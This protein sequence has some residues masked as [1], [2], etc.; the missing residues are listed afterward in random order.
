[1]PGRSAGGAG[2]RRPGHPPPT[3]ARG[4]TLAIGLLVLLIVACAAP[5]DPGDAT[6]A[7][8]PAPP[9]PPTTLATTAP[10]SATEPGP[11]ASPDPPVAV[12]AVAATPTSTVALAAGSPIG[13]ATATHSPSPT[14]AEVPTP[15]PERVRVVGGSQGVNMRR[16]PGTASAV[17]KAVRDGTDVTIVGPD[18]E[19]EGRIWRNVRDGDAVGWIVATALR[20]APTPTATPAPTPT[21]PAT[22]TPTSTATPSPAPTVSSPPAV[23]PTGA[24]TPP[25]ATPR[26]ERVEVVGTGGQGANLRAE[27]GTAGRLL[28]TV[29]DG[30]RLA[31]VG[32]DRE[33]DGRTWRNVRGDGGT[34]GWLIDEAVRPVDA[35]EPSA[36]GTPPAPGTTPPAAT[37]TPTAGSTPGPAAGLTA[38]PALPAPT[39]DAD[40]GDNGGDNEEPATP[41][42][43]PTPTPEPER[44]EVYGSDPQGANLRARPGRGGAVRRSLPDG[45]RLTIVGEDQVVDGV[46][47]RNVQTEDG[48]IGWLALE[49]VRTVVTPTPTPR[50]GSAGI[51]APIPALEQPP[52]EFSEAERAATP[53]RPGQLKGDAASGRYYRPDHPDYAGLRL[54]VRCFDE[55]SR[56][57]ASGFLPAPPPGQGDDE[58]APDAPAP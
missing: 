37:R 25:P 54:R 52:E 12:V 1:M 38:T 11:A 23:L 15:E 43:S 18:R 6:V 2:R 24:S 7:E 19:S 48:T 44:V 56:A 16:E 39:A 31:V 27:P 34:V 53:C 51:G 40:D 22:A 47:W 41:T 21:V 28:Q 8:A 42:P 57:E 55:A 36:P 46:R 45:T 14:P 26:P 3:W 58:D 17:V 33:V 50:P 5:P 30:T 20:P 49:V 29:P 32:P 35:A 4:A 13:G 10:A 9:A